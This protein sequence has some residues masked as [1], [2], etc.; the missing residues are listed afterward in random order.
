M[1][2]GLTVTA[3]PGALRETASASGILVQAFGI[4][5]EIREQREEKKAGDGE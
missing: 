2:T 4:T 3:A 1:I 5:P